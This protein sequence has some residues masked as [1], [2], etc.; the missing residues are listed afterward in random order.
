MT[1]VYVKNI[2]MV[3]SMKGK[4]LPHG[5]EQEMPMFCVNCG[6]ILKPGARFC[7]RCGTP[8]RV[9]QPQSQ[10]VEQ[11]NHR[12]ESCGAMMRCVNPQL[13]VCDYCNSQ[14]IPERQPVQPVQPVQPYY[15]PQ[16]A[17]QPAKPPE[18]ELLDSI[19]AAA[20]RLFK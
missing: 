14:W 12:C 16:P 11:V 3:R 4:R 13:Y 17:A 10:V 6:N 8:A 5:A 15:P 7:N 19:Y 2:M 18:E 20:K 1:G 9:V